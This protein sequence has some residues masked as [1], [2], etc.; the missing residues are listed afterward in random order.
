MKNMLRVNNHQAFY[1]NGSLVFVTYEYPYGLS[2][3]FIETEIQHLANHFTRVTI[4]PS[5]AFFSKNWIKKQPVTKRLVPINCEVVLPACDSIGTYLMALKAIIKLARNVRIWLP[6]GGALLRVMH[7]IIRDSTK[8]ALFFSRTAAILRNKSDINMAYSYWKSPATIALCLCNY[9]NNFGL[10]IVTRCHGGDL[11]YNLPEL[12]SRPYDPFVS[13]GVDYI[14]PI[15]EMGAK[16]LVEHGFDKSK[17]KVSRLGVSLPKIVSRHSVDGI[18]RIVSC[19]YIIPVKRVPLIAKALARIKHP[20]IWTHFGDGLEMNFLKEIIIKFPAHG[21]AVFPGSLP[22]K[23]ILDYYQSEPVD[24]FINVSTSEGIPVSIMEALSAGIPCLATDVGGTSE[25]V[26]SS[27]GLL[28]SVHADEHD[29]ALAIT[30]ELSAQSTLFI[31]RRQARKRAELTCS[32]AINYT[33]FALFLHEASN[34][35]SC[36]YKDGT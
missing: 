19:S 14:V 3:P 7:E 35:S 2:E 26:D 21:G 31:K 5:R 28:L 24:L 34:H 4:I 8:A 11:Y 36:V 20:F 29:I 1:E 30:N 15:S 23:K 13:K 33:N 17:V 16:H 18:W 9:I 10:T 27:V 12:P 32:A 6:H 22:N 25:L